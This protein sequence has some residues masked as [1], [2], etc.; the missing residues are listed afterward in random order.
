MIRARDSAGGIRTEL[1]FRQLEKDLVFSIWKG[2]HAQPGARRWRYDKKPPRTIFRKSGE[3]VFV[4]T[5]LHTGALVPTLDLDGAP[6]RALAIAVVVD[7]A[8]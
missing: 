4:D 2:P 3:D 1:A 7:P 5:L 6:T 8:G